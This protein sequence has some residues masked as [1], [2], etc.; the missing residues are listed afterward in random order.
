MPFSYISMLETDAKKIDKLISQE[1]NMISMDICQKLESDDVDIIVTQP[2]IKNIQVKNE[3]IQNMFKGNFAKTQEILREKISTTEL[4]PKNEI[5]FLSSELLNKRINLVF[6]E[7]LKKYPSSLHTSI[8]LDR[9]FFLDTLLSFNKGEISKES[10]E[11]E[12]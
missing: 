8:I 1:I 5:D 12:R 4:K 10:I 2:L 9:K 7:M 3:F 6:E 11:N